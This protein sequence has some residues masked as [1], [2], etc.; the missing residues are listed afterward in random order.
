MSEYSSVEKPFLQKL[1]EI[2]W[3][4]IDQKQGIPENPADSL[5]TNFN[6]WAIKSIFSEK[7]KELNTWITDEQ[8]NQCWDKIMTQS[9]KLLEVNEATFTM[10]RKGIDLEGKNEVTGEEN[11]NVRLVAFG[12]EYSKNRSCRPFNLRK[13]CF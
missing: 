4:V 11:P 13:L 9:G 3:N 6:D 7:V 5:R 1:K 2:G 8:I 10:L 12:K